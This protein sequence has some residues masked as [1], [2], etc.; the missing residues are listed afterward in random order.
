MQNYS[1]PQSLT[2]TP[3]LLP[4]CWEPENGCKQNQP[5]NISFVIWKCWERFILLLIIYCELL[6][7]MLLKKMEEKK[8]LHWIS[9]TEEILY[10]KTNLT[11]LSP[12]Q[13]LLWEIYD[14]KSKISR[15]IFLLD[16][17]FKIVSLSFPVCIYC[18]L[19]TTHHYPFLCLRTSSKQIPFLVL[20]IVFLY[21]SLHFISV[22]CLSMGGGYLFEQGQLT[23]CFNIEGYNYPSPSNLHIDLDSRCSSLLPSKV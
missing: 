12:F 20:C 19:I 3:G 15:I 14:R 2:F 22:A 23:S 17:P 11:W 13:M 9:D 6:P 18:I 10:I 7:L 5:T 21:G 1:I 4:I 16:H 8:Y